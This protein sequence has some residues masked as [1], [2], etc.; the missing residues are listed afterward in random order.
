MSCRRDLTSVSHPPTAGS[1][2]QYSAGRGKTRPHPKCIDGG[3]T[4]ILVTVMFSGLRFMTKGTQSPKSAT[5]SCPLLE[6][7]SHFKKNWATAHLIRKSQLRC[8][9]IPPSAPPSHLDFD[10][11]KQTNRS[12]ME[13]ILLVRMAQYHS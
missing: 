2:E 7:L 5:R 12:H 1:Q 9:M 13:T 3:N 8:R 4:L 10:H 11:V 6:T